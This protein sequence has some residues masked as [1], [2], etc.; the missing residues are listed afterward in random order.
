MSAD[1]RLVE[2]AEGLELPWCVAFLPD[3]RL[4]VTERPGRLRQISPEGEM[5]SV[6]GPPQALTSEMLK[7][8]PSRAKPLVPS[9]VDR[10]VSAGNP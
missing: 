3:G 9:S 7:P 4:L 6:F 5:S 8:G 1:Y 10:A 2:V